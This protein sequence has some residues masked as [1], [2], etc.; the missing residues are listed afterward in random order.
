MTELKTAG[1]Q[2]NSVSKP[3]QNITKR[4]NGAVESSSKIT[5]RRS[6]TLDNIAYHLGIP[7]SDADEVDDDRSVYVTLLCALKTYSKIN[8]S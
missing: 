1:N 2:Q 3:Q 5:C 7:K 8:M 4:N 6:N